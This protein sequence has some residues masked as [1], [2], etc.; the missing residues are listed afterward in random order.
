MKK[1]DRIFIAGEHS[2]VGSNFTQFLTD[3]GFNNLLSGSSCGV[4]LLDQN[5][6]NRFFE[7]EKPEYVFLFH[8]KSGGINANINLSAEFIYDNLQ[9]QNNII[10]YAYVCKIK[11]LFLLGSSCVYPKNSLQPIKEN[12]L[13]M[14]ELEKT[15]EA[16]SIAKIAGIKM[17]QAYNRQYGTNF[18]SGIPASIYGV[19]NHFDFEKSH[20]ME[21]LIIKFH[22]ARI[23]NK[24]TVSL[25]GTGLP[26]REFIYVDDAVSACMFL[27]ENYEE[28]E[29]I[30]IG[31]GQDIS[32][33]ELAGLVKEITGFRGEVIFDDS[34]P[35]G[36][37]RKLL[38]HNKITMLGWKPKI[39]L[40]EGVKLTYQ[41][42][43]SYVN[44]R[45]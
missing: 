16:Y 42:Y 36:V 24:Q 11:K 37:L 34:K 9:I 4:D 33:R 41:R 20:V 27:M 13:L 31:C 19:G 23:T 28:N 18:I 26:R 25:W 1:N 12:Y 45:S 22:E 7:K 43:K 39:S 40:E 21:A 5:S 14:G 17:C 2:L 38:D 8:F 30:N 15:S 44:E 32:I 6:V 3:E 35:E 29:V 10:H